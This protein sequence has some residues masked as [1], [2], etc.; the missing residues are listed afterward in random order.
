MCHV[1]QA[2]ALCALVVL[3]ASLV[4]CRAQGGGFLMQGPDGDPA[5]T[6]GAGTKAPPAECT[7][8][9]VWRVR[10]GWHAMLKAECCGGCSNGFQVWKVA[11]NGGTLAAPTGRSGPASPCPATL[12][13]LL[14]CWPRHCSQ[15][16]WR[17]SPV[18]LR[19]FFLRRPS[20]GPKRC[21][22]QPGPP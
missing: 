2:G 18:L 17:S 21:S 9:A 10:D 13:T 7:S 3:F 4:Q 14:P 11:K 8:E 20:T 5:A 19:I 22:V 12:H 1:L 15:R 16:H 6:S